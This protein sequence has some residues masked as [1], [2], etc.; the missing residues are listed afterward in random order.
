LGSACSAG[1]LQSGSSAHHYA[2]IEGGGVPQTYDNAMYTG[3]VSAYN[4]NLVLTN[5]EVSYNKVGDD[6]IN[7][8]QGSLIAKMCVFRGAN[9][10]AIDLDYS[11]GSISG[12][13]FTDSGND[14]ID[15]MTSPVSI[16][17]C[18]IEKSGDKGISI[19]ERSQPI[20]YNNII[21]GC[22]IG[23]EI[24]DVSDPQIDSCVIAHCG[25]G[26]NAYLKNDKYQGG[27][28]GTIESTMIIGC[29]TLASA[30]KKSYV[31]FINCLTDKEIE[32][33][34]NIDISGGVMTTNDTI[35]YSKVQQGEYAGIGLAEAIDTWWE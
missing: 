22:N 3:M 20:I 2:L 15:L 5:S 6:G 14:A 29:G 16:E 21:S 28:L 27:G 18:Y 31:K 30:D 23:I 7:I 19:G 8:K 25:T 35:D 11:T 10:D 12:C 9:S 24:K 17:N 4:T 13:Y 33:S 32:Q 26:I 34:A 1:A